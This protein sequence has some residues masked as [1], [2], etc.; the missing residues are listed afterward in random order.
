M[1]GVSGDMLLGA[2]VDLGASPEKITV[3][4]TTLSEHIPH[5]KSLALNVKE[6]SRHGLRGIQASVLVDERLQHRTGG[7]LMDALERYLQVSQLSH[8]AR[9]LATNSLESLLKA[10]AF[11]HSSTV[12]GVHLHEAGS[13]DTLADIVGAAVALEDLG[14]GGLD[15][16]TLPVNVGNGMVKSHHGTMAVPPPATM[17]ILREKSLPFDGGI[18]GGELATPTGVSILA[19]LA[20]PIET[21]PAMKISKIGYGAGSKE[22]DTLPNLLRLSLGQRSGLPFTQEE[23][24]VLETNIDDISSEVIGYLIGSLLKVGAKDAYVTP[25][26]GKKSRPSFKVTALA[27][28]DCVEQLINIFFKETGTLGV[29]T[30]RCD[31]F[32][33]QRQL[34]PVK[35]EVAGKAF[36]MKVKVAKDISG[37]VLSIKPEFEDVKK[38]ASETGVPL[39]EI[40][41]KVKKRAKEL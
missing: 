2:L 17:E 15:V 27:A 21:Y 39:R 6:T 1:A 28:R 29:R 14:F 22:L 5:C 20:K 26:T 18:T 31:R 7:E 12:E 36:E 25:T 8:R 3:A 35:V 38:I 32:V 19:N 13:A 24:Y 37:R 10:E 40:I 16:Y 30:Y 33:L 9:D 4:F 41:E 34:H 11:L 23:L